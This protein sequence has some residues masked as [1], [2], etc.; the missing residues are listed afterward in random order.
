MTDAVDRLARTIAKLHREN[1]NL[2]S[3]SLRVGE[4]VGI[5][6]LRVQW[7]DS[8]IISEEKLVIPKLFTT[9]YPIPNRWQDTSGNMID[10]TLV[11]KIT[12]SPGDYVVIAPDEY[13]KVWYII[14]LLGGG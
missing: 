6:P 8:I 12:L 7:G 4:V 3:T 10:D 5:N 9:G 2:P 14:D 11:W 13:L 1:R